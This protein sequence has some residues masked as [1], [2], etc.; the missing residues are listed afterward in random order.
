MKR[1]NIALTCKDKE[2]EDH[3]SQLS[4]L[5]DQTANSAYVLG[6]NSKPHITVIQFDAPENKIDDLKSAVKKS[7]HENSSILA[8]IKDMYYADFH[9]KHEKYYYGLHV[10]KTHL[11]QGIHEFVLTEILKPLELTPTLRR[12]GDQYAPHFTLGL[13]DTP[14]SEQ[15]LIHPALLQNIS[16]PLDMELHLCLSE[17][18]G[19]LGDIL[20]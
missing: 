1:Y 12:F 14:L 5:L 4:Q 18:F 17:E 11:I 2:T 3:L 15:T 16:K 20:T 10:E 6:K 8:R 13:C 9:P 7:Q 19:R